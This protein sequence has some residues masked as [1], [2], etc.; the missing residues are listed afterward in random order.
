M[1]RHASSNRIHITM[2][3]EFNQLSCLTESIIA[4]LCPDCTAAVKAVKPGFLP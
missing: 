3:Y 1:S 2:P 4:E